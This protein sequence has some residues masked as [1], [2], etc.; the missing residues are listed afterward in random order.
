MRAEDV[1]DL[2]SARPS[3]SVRLVGGFDQWV[4]GPGTA[5]T[6]VIPAGR[7]RAVSKQSGWIAPLVIVGGV[8]G[9][10]WELEG[11]TVKIGWFSE[12]AQP[13]P[14]RLDAEVGRLGRIVGR[15]LR[16][17]VVRT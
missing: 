16:P 4:L 13:S 6:H 3:D 8:V 10:T 1:D 5:D 12:V 17:D 9:G 15:S 14:V 2:A 11:D 7:R